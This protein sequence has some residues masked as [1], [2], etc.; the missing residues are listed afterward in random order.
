MILGEC[1]Y[2]GT[3]YVVDEDDYMPGCRESE[4]YKC[5]ECGKIVGE[6]FTSGIPRVRKISPKQAEDIRK[7]ITEQFGI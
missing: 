4:T 1:Q 5:P 6:V 7:E 3:N 2:C